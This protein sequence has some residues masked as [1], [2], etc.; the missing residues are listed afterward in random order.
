MS[1]S[2]TST[3][4]DTPIRP[5]SGA[6]GGSFAVHGECFAVESGQR[7][8]VVDLTDRVIR[9]VKATGVREG[10][11]SLCSLHTTCGVFINE[12]QKALV[13]DITG[14]LET[15]VAE[16]GRWRHND[17]EHSDCDRAN[18]DSH[19]RA[20]LLGHGLTLQVSGG[21]IVLGQWQRILMGELDGPRPRT[22]RVQVMGIA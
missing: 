5:V 13:D 21:E 8:E 3:V 10:L 12:H 6:S 18:A 4:R 22:F 1:R 14:L 15:L 11:V 9:F 7:V 17:P 2:S 16:D 19:L 20:L